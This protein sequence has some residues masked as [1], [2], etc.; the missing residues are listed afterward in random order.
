[1]IS[2][3]RFLFILPAIVALAAC[4]T[5]VKTQLADLAHAD[6]LRSDSLVQIKNEM[7]DEVMA[8]TQFVNDLNAQI[9][10]LKVPPTL[11]LTSN[12][13]RESAVED[14][15]AERGAV[16]Q[17]IKELVAR[18]DSSQARLASLRDRAKSFA[19][20]DSLLETQVAEYEK[21][22]S[23]MR[24]TLE[25]QRADFQATVDQQNKQ[26]AALN[27]KVDTVTKANAQ[28]STQRA[29]LTDTVGQLVTEKNTV[30]YVVGTKADLLKQGIL[31]E[32]GR[33]SLLLF[34]SR[35]VVPA[36]DLDPS[37]F[38]R[39]DRL[40]DRSITFPDGEYTIVS[41]QNPQYATPVGSV[42]GK[43]TGGLKI[44]QP[45]KFWEASKFLVVVRN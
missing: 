3:K 27:S 40:R 33:K 21:T 32:E 20:R 6:S 31:V 45:E 29:A 1:M 7:L 44:D 25:R 24:Q 17:R 19:D 16:S 23:D 11:K 30:Y 14:M 43:I 10:K 22:I 5:K 39:I 2:L 8:S 15:K 42:D 26:I 4:D 36:R 41:R 12:L 38:T 28:L 34:G 9:A 37:K 35:P 18:L 13:T